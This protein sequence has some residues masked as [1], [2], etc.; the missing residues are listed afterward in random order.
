MRIEYPIF[1]C[2][3]DSGDIHRYDSIYELQKELEKIDVENDEYRAWDRNG[4]SVVFGV[5]EPVWLQLHLINHSDS[6]DLKRCLEQWA[7]AVGVDI[8]IGG[9]SAEQL[10]RAYE[11]VAAAQKAASYR[12]RY[13]RRLLRRFRVFW[14]RIHEESDRP[15]V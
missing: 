3:R 2:A 14:L 6:P 4:T 8:K 12:P 15:D 5:Q 11:Q 10:C 9:S 1:V 13:I 7:R